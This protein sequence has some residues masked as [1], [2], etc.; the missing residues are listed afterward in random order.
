M[1]SKMKKTQPSIFAHPKKTIVRPQQTA[2]LVRRA[3]I[4]HV[5]RTIRLLGISFKLGRL[6]NAKKKKLELIV[7]CHNGKASKNYKSNT[8]LL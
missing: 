6:K 4:A 2:P 1:T 8:L 3:S 7:L 5:F